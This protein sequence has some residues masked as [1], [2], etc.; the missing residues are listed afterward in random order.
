MY[1]IES[2]YTPLHERMDPVSGLLLGALI[3]VSLVASYLIV[4][5]ISL[6]SRI[7]I[8]YEPI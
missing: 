2:E 5:T 6:C 4:N 1:K 8:S 3:C 7:R